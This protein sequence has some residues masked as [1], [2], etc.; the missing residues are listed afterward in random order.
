MGCRGRRRDA[1]VGLADLVTLTRLVE[2]LNQQARRALAPRLTVTSHL[3][4]AQ[5]QLPIFAGP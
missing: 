1:L 3:T 4:Q 5:D 2:E